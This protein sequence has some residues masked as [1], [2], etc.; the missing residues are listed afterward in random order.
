M[1]PA[2]ITV[3]LHLD[4][5]TARVGTS[6]KGVITITNHTATAITVSNNECTVNDGLAVGL[7]KPGTPFEPAFAAQACS[8]SAS[9][10]PGSN[11]YKVTISTTYLGCVPDAS[12]SSEPNPII[13][14][15]EGSLPPLPVGH[16]ETKIVL[17]GFPKATAFPSP[18]AVTLWAPT[19]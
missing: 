2:P 7:T 18:I 10:K 8:P 6:I 5:T 14:T 3:H 17:L 13:C 15:K 16:Y 11:R 12:D 19:S 1:P 9:L 4:K